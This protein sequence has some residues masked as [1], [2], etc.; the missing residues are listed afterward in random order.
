MKSNNLAIILAIAAIVCVGKTFYL[1]NTSLNKNTAVAIQPQPRIYQPKAYIAIETNSTEIAELSQNILYWL[2]RRTKNQWTAVDILVGE[3]V[4]NLYSQAATRRDLEALSEQVKVMPSSDQALIQAIQRFKNEVEQNKQQHV[5][6]FI[7]TKGT[8]N[9]SSL[10]AIRQIC[11]KLAQTSSTTAHITIIGLSP[12]NR[13]PMSTAV[14][15]LSGGV[16][17]AST[18]EEEWKELIKF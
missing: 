11:Q 9:S 13:L 5:Y 10:A 16:Q 4:Q 14:A 1:K 3:K 17:F 18:A 7:V 12:E 2:A 6:G 15:P 8:A